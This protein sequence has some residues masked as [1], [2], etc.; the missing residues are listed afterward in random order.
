M[1][2]VPFFIVIL[3]A[4]VL[5]F[6]SCTTSKPKPEPVA[7]KEID[8]I[9][10]LVNLL[11][12]KKRDQAIK[13]LEKLAVQ[14]PDT[15]V[16]HQAN[17][18]LADLY[19]EQR[20]YVNAYKYYA[21]IINSGSQAENEIPARIGAGRCLVQLRKFPETLSIVQRILTIDATR[22]QQMEAHKML[23]LA[24]GFANNKLESLKSLVFLA[25]NSPEQ[26]DRESYKLRA[27]DLVDS[28]LSDEEVREVSS[29]SQFEFLRGAAYYRLGM[30]LFEQGN[31]DDAK[32][33]L[34]SSLDYLKEGQMFEKAGELI[35]QIESRRRTNAEVIGAVLPLTG[36]NSKVGQKALRGLQLGLGIFGPN[37]SRYKLS[38]V[39]SEGNPE[40]ARRVF[41]NM[42]MVDHPI[43]V[44]GSLLSKTA[45][46]VAAKAQEF[47]VPTIGLSQKSGITEAGN[48]VFRNSVTSEMQVA[49]L[50]QIAMTQRKMT[51][52]AILYPNDAY[53]VEFA[54]LFWDEVLARGGQITGVQTYDPK[55]TDF[56][57]PVK[58]LVGTYFVESREAEYNLR[59][60][61]WKSKQK[62]PS[63]TRDMVKDIL[64]PIIDFEAI[65]IPDGTKALGQIAPM[66]AYNDIDKVTLIGT[67]L[68]NMGGL[69]DR[70][71]KFVE[72]C[73]FVD[74]PS[75]D[76]KRD[77]FA[78]A[79]FKKTFGYDPDSF[80]LQAYDTGLI[81]RQMLDT[82]VNSREQMRQQLASISNFP[83]STGPLAMSSRREIFRPLVVLTVEKSQIKQ[84]H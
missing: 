42:I 13:A 16:G 77:G 19:Y 2:R 34:S 75:P 41:K 33:Y 15:S 53:G 61:A 36:K 1:K 3:L 58:R 12:T 54:N 35:A 27:F 64:P 43:A 51:K 62:N 18:A 63:S 44:V 8:Q 78:T 73:L 37:K 39:D 80:E 9:S 82:G 10:K 68:W 40:I 25:I 45:L 23:Y 52:F 56:R 57:G 69:V 22:E 29:K 47:G 72:N 76:P 67:N 30:T 7:Q 48:F 84:I 60:Q 14:S 31:Y 4:S 21:A 50:V 71:G 81:L 74:S 38:V 32:S 59:F 49:R 55:E 24:H 66:L 79:N 83:G 65:F 46:P 6:V 70:G 28:R 5:V 17:K 20:D 26:A 11:K